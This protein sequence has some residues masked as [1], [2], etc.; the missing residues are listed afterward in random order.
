[1]HTLPNQ[2]RRIRKSTHGRT[3][4]F[5]PTSSA[6]IREVKCMG[7]I[8]RYD[9]ASVY[10]ILPEVYKSDQ[11]I[12]CWHCCEEIEDKNSLVPI[13]RV[14]DSVERMYHVFGATCSSG[15][16]KAYILEHTSFDKGQQLNVL[17]KMLRDVFGSCDPVVETPPR[18]ALRRF[19]GVFDPKAVRR[20]RC[21]VVQPPFVSYTM[22][23]E[24]RLAGESKGIVPALPMDTSAVEEADTLDEPQ[25]PSIFADFLRHRAA[26]S[27]Q[28]PPSAPIKR[29]RDTADG[30]M[31]RFM[32]K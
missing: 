31:T 13:P 29:R 16:A 18:S 11:P 2:Q 12:V 24:E 3:D 17:A 8:T 26:A 27:E 4:L 5:L 22:L 14:F 23:I 25:P 28:P 19:G 21:Q 15:C 9:S 6:I 20:V 30:P 32:K 1:M 10:H 7:G